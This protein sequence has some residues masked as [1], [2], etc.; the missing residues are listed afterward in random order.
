MVT[1][2]LDLPS[3]PV[4]LESSFEEGRQEMLQHL[5]SLL[6]QLSDSDHQ[7]LLL[8]PPHRRHH[9]PL[10]VEV[11]APTLLPAELAHLAL[12]ANLQK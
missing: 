1:V 4:Q 10:R 7:V 12:M 8:H 3:L 11:V 6:P 2:D 5:K 9:R